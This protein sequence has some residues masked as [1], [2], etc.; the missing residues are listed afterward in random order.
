MSLPTRYLWAAS[1]TLAAMLLGWFGYGWAGGSLLA[2]DSA[3]APAQAAAEATLPLVQAW[4]AAW[5]TRDEAAWLALFA[6]QAHDDAL[7][8]WN[9][10]EYMTALQLGRPA[11]GGRRMLSAQAARG[12]DRLFPLQLQLWYDEDTRLITRLQAE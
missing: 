6:P 12:S 10:Y 3:S 2:G 5:D 11:W 8:V 1:A 4:Q 9:A 7:A